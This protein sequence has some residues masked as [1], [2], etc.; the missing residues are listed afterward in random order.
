MGM[1]A[2]QARLLSITARLSNNEH[3]AENLSFE[4]QRLADR[5]EQITNEYNEALN[6]TKLTVLTGFNGSEANY[7]DISYKLMTG[8]QMAQST[9][10]YIVTYTRNRVLVTEDIA[11]AFLKSK[12]NFNAFLSALNGGNGY[13]ISDVTVKSTDIDVDVVKN[14]EAK[15][16]EAWD[17]YFESVGIN[18]GDDEHDNINYNWVNTLDSNGKAEGVGFGYVTYTNGS[19]T[20]PINYEGTTAE[21]RDLFDYA[22]AITESFYRSDFDTSQYKMANNSDNI[23]D[24]S[25]YRNLF[26]RI[27]QRGMFTYTDNANKAKANPDNFIYNGDTVG[28]GKIAKNPI[29]DNATFEAALR[30]GTLRLEYYNVSEKAFNSITVSEDNCIQEFEDERAISRAEVKYTQDMTAL[31]KLDKKYDLNLKKLDTEHNALQTEYDSM[32]TIIDKNI[33]SS[34][35]TFS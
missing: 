28:T 31:E 10:Q 16:H 30:D 18:Y 15:I 21:S 11:N 2:S 8:T 26:N 20:V 13:S 23:S 7:E 6:A 1:S 25:Y 33:E 34:F 12:G 32:K 22:M 29:E 24:I 9:R 35:K 17:K 14:T 5:S 3:T 19:T 27:Q 4:K